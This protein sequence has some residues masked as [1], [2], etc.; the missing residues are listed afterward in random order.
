MNEHRLFGT[1][2]LTGKLEDERK[3]KERQ[4]I[5]GVLLNKLPQW[6]PQGSSRIT[7]QRGKEPENLPIYHRSTGLRP[8]T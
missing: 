5:Q 8:I 6:T 7:Q 2:T 4:P 1:T 3:E